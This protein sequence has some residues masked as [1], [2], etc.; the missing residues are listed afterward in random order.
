MKRVIIESPYAGDVDRNVLYARAALK[1]SLSLNEAPIASHLLYTQV[2]N[3]NILSEREQGID[4]GLAWRK[5][6]ELAV[7]YVD[8]GWSDG[9]LAA[10][11]VYELEGTPFCERSIL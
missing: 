8:F 4:A 6:A 3:D 9:M 11:A 7:F 10:K 5:A 1:H 2:L